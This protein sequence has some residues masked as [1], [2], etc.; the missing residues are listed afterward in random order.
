MTN[1]FINLTTIDGLLM[2]VSWGKKV[3]PDNQIPI[4]NGA[5]M[6]LS[7]KQASNVQ[8]AG[9]HENCFKFTECVNPDIVGCESGYK[10][11]GYDKDDC[12][13]VSLN[14]R[15]HIAHL[16]TNYLD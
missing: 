16:L 7:L 6:S 15:N 10:M 12:N 3:K 8:T 2:Q 11:V 1:I 14:L 5:Y 4:Q 9:L 13:N